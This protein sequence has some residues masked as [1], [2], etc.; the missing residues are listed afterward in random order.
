MVAVVVLDDDDVGTL[1]W[2][3]D[4]ST[5]PEKWA[6][7][8]VVGLQGPVVEFETAVEVWEEEDEVQCHDAGGDTEDAPENLAG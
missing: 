3:W 4:F 7:E 6:K 8:D 1:G 2:G 5:A